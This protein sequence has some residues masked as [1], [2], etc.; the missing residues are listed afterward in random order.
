MYPQYWIPS[1]GGIAIRYSF[2]YKR[3]CVEMYRDVK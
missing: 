3:M 1:V 2:K